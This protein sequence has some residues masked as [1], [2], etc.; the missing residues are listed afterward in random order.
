[1]EKR[2]THEEM[3]LRSQQCLRLLHLPAPMLTVEEDWSSR[4][5]CVNMRANSNRRSVNLL[6]LMDRARTTGLQQHHL[7]AFTST[8]DGFLS[9]RPMHTGV[10]KVHARKK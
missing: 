7:T 8:I 2:K 9:N 10:L 1:M 6:P 3:D 5:V 4:E